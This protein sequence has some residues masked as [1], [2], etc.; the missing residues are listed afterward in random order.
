MHLHRSLPLAIALAA[1]VGTAAVAKGPVVQIHNAPSKIIYKTALPPPAGVSYSAVV[2]NKGHL[3]RG[4]G[5]T[6]ASRAEG[7]GTTEVDFTNDVSGCAFVATVGEPASNGSEPASF[8]TV[9][10]RSGTP[11]GVYVETLDHSGSLANLPFHID[12]GC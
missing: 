3:V 10:G 8:I 4:S 5:A 2:N 6:G 9:V 7:N 11:Q 1:V 12:V